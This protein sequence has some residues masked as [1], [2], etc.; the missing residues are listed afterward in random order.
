MKPSL[1]VLYIVKHL[2][3]VRRHFAPALVTVLNYLCFSLY[4]L[5]KITFQYKIMRKFGFVVV[6]SVRTERS[7]VSNGRT[8]G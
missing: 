5:S 8:I 1:A 4:S 2:R 6:C 3:D 7:D